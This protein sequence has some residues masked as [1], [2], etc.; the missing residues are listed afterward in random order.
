MACRLTSSSLRPQVTLAAL[1]LGVACCF[2]VASAEPATPPENSVAAPAPRLRVVSYNVF[3]FL[4]RSKPQIK[5]P[6]SR[7]TAL[8]IL[9]A[10]A[11]DIAVLVETGGEAAV[12][13][14]RDDLAARGQP[15]AFASTVL[16]FDQ[17]RRLG[18]LA[19]I[20]P[21]QVAHVTTATYRL[22]GRDVPVRRGF[23]HCVFEWSGYRLHLLAAHL[24][25]K[26][27]DPLGQTDMRRYEARLL[28]YQIDDILAA[29]PGANVL[30]VGDLNDTPES[31]PVSTLCS[32]RSAPHRQL[33]D[34]RPVDR[35]GLSW[36]HCWDSA[37]TY[38][39]IDYA[40][41]SYGLLPEVDLGATEVAFFP[42]WALAS[43]HRPLVVTLN[44]RDRS[45]TP[46]MLGWFDRN[47]RVPASPLS[48][49]H[50]GRVVGTRKARVG[51]EA[52][53][54]DGTAVPTAD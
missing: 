31:S 20:A 19:R 16:A 38:S 6:E 45:V 28:R 24:K 51:T 29:E 7:E 17:E 11:P 33:Y 12:T 9:A 15:Y 48:S 5:S 42:E 27:Y 26:A 44:L 35:F 37:D 46:E 21:V 50:E 49:F 2:R 41:V 36:T 3:N 52:V 30:L 4:D 40:M 25:S 54:D 32:R 47:V 53:S 43:D 34:L 10:L 13:E 18:V 23:A 8:S 14:I 39:R 22:Q 1:L